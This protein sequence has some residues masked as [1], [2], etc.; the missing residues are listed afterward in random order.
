VINS[1]AK[2][3]DGTK[4]DIYSEQN[5][6]HSFNEFAEHSACKP[7]GLRREV[8][9][10]CGLLSEFRT[11]G[12]TIRSYPLWLVCLCTGLACGAFGRLFGVDWPAFVP[13]VVGSASGQR[14]RHALVVRKQN[15][16][17]TSGIVSFCSAFLAG[18][19]ARILGSLHPETATVAAVLL[20]VPGVA[21]LKYSDGCNRR[22]TKPCR[23]SWGDCRARVSTISV[24]ARIDSLSRWV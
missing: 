19:G 17:V 11:S 9:S 5:A 6:R 15:I 4:C 13:V 22:K 8:K 16:F 10:A 1:S 7:A 20:L 24:V 12:F 23:R 2:F 14:I 21:V 3:C 18:L